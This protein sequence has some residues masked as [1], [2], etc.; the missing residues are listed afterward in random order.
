MPVRQIITPENPILRRKANRVTTFDTRFQALIDDM[1]ATMQDANGIG[2]A[3]PQIA[4]SQRVIVVQLSD[5]E[6]A[7]EEFGKDAGVLHV[8]INPK[9]ARAS[10]EIVEGI[11]ACLSIPGYYGTVERHVEVTVKGQDRNGKKIR[12]KARDWLARAFQHEID[13]LDGVLYIDR[14]S[15]VWRAG[16]R[17]SEDQELSEEPSSVEEDAA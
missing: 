15:E 1:V 6:A 4:S 8:V 7:R 10:R 5:D 13:H 9:I 14:A 3:A 2:L 16:E 17:E 12:I 11:E